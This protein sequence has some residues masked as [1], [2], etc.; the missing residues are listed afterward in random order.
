[1]RGG[2]DVSGGFLAFSTVPTTAGAALERLRID[3]SGRL[4]IGTTA[5]ATTL[6]VAGTITT[7][8]GTQSGYMHLYFLT[9]ATNTVR[10]GRISKNYDSPYDFNIFA[11]SATTAAPI[12][13]NNSTTLEAGRFDTSGRL[14]VGTSTARSWSGVTSLLQ[15][16][17][18]SVNGGSF[19]LSTNTN[20]SNGSFLSFIKSRGTSLN[21]NTVKSFYFF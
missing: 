16:E 4:G 5:P 20:D 18:T 8:R 12:V 15:L 21:S 19:S 2:R 17:G 7:G 9:E 3:S 11:S 6:D 1:M 14:L 10:A 13:F